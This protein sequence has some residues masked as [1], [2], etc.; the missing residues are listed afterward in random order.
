MKQALAAVEKNMSNAEFTVEELSRELYM[1]RVALYKKLLAL[2]GKTP[3]E[4]IRI[5]R[6]KR[7]AQFLEKTNKTIAEVAYEVGFNNPKNFAKYF[8]EEFNVV[9]SQ[10]SSAKKD[11]PAP[12]KND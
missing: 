9:P 6:L 8:K 4:F 11:N 7:G 5:I 2:T 12:V 3:I 10:Y 1:S